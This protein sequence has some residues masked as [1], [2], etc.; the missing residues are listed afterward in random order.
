MMD[1]YEK[2]KR[3]VEEARRSQA[4]AEGALAEV[5]NRIKKEFGCENLTKAEML[6][7]KLKKKELS[8]AELYERAKKEFEKKWRAAL[9][10]TDERD[11]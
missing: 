7:A 11:D 4:R 3:E 2:L 5:M 9:E 10:G 6:L 1:D 8:A